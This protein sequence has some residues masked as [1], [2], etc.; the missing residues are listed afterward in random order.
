ML[1]KYI[2]QFRTTTDIK[3]GSDFTHYMDADGSACE[4]IS[5]MMEPAWKRLK[6]ELDPPLK[7]DCEFKAVM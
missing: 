4:S 1:E 7:K 2:F 3:A 5:N 6:E